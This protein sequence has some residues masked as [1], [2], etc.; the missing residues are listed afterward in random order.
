MT[1][2]ST[3]SLLAFALACILLCGCSTPSSRIKKQQVLFDTYP[4]SVQDTIK[5]GKVNIGF[6]KDMTYM[7]LGNP[8]RKYTRRTASGTSEI[9]SYT[10]SYSTPSR[11]RVEGSFRIRDAAGNYRT[12]RD[13]VWVDVNQDIEYE[14]KRIEFQD[15]IVTAIEDVEM[16]TGF[17]SPSL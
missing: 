6:T 16:D 4:V 11:Q 5:S 8:N 1:I 14:T 13:S 10:S 3:S 9:W 7:A 12:V 2:K 15:D 17:V